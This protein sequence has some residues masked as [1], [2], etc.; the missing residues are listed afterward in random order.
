[1]SI[2]EDHGDGN[3]VYEA[4]VNC[5]LSGRYGVTARLTPAGDTWDNHIPNF[6]VWA[7]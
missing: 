7:G 6:V 3:Y 1:M 5:S 4:T 2:V